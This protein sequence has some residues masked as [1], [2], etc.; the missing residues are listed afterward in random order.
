MQHRP[1]HALTI[2]A[3]AIATGIAPWP[4]M[5]TAHAAEDAVLS[6]PSSLAMHAELGFLALTNSSTTRVPAPQLGVGVRY[7]ASEHFGASIGYRGALRLSGNRFARIV[8]T[9]H[10]LPVGGFAAVEVGRARL[11]GTLALLPTL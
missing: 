8:Y 9:V 10:D 7:F 5:G 4:R 1:I 11:L 3:V 2:A 6:A